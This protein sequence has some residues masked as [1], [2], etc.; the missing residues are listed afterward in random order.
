[1]LAETRVSHD[2]S[3][4]GNALNGMRA[5]IPDN[6]FRTFG[7]S[8]YWLWFLHTSTPSV[9]KMMQVS[10]LSSPMPAILLL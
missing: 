3:K 8:I 9:M 10:T 1:V 2:W 6:Y 5:D 4:W 7:S